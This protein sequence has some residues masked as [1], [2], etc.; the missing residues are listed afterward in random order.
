MYIYNVYICMVF[1]TLWKP[2]ELDL[3]INFQ[4]KFFFLT[5]WKLPYLLFSW[6]FKMP[7]KTYDLDEWIFMGHY[8][9]NAFRGKSWIF[10]GP[11]KSYM[12]WKSTTKSMIFISWDFH[13][14]EKSM[15][16]LQ[17]APNTPWN[18]CPCF[19]HGC[20]KCHEKPVI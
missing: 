17:K 8:N 16:L 5:P 3:E 18:Y 14:H 1:K 9:L 12:P 13:H 2:N 15:N 4:N 20:L 19:F 7:G 6:V 10:R 11:W